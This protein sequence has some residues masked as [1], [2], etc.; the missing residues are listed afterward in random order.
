MHDHDHFDLSYVFHT[1]IGRDQLAQIQGHIEVSIP[2]GRVHDDLPADELD[3]LLK[4]HF[5]IKF[6]TELFFGG[7]LTREGIDSLS[8][9]AGLPEGGDD[10]LKRV[11]Y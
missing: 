4:S 10:F 3:L 9:Q 1:N 11:G 6:C 5:L 2:R 8:K 7:N